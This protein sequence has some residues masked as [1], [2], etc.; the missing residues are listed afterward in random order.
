MISFLFI[1]GAQHCFSCPAGKF[2]NTGSISPSEC[3]PGAYCPKGIEYPESCPAGT[4][5]N[6]TNLEGEEQCSQCPPGRLQT[7]HIAVHREFL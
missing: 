7:E 1:L 3:F 6:S 5:S 4:Y 2:C